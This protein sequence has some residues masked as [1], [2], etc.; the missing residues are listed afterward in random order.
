[1]KR[2]NISDN[3]LTEAGARS[4][5]RTILRGLRCF[6]MMQSCTFNSATGLF[7]HSNPSLD[8]PYTLNLAEPYEVSIL[9][10]LINMV[11]DSTSQCTFRNLRYRQNERDKGVEIVPEYSDGET[12]LRCGSNPWGIPST[13]LLTV[14]FLHQLSIPKEDMAIDEL[15]FNTILAIVV[16]ARS[17]KDRKNWLFLM[18]MDAYFTTSQAQDLIDILDDRRLLGPGGVSV[19]EFFRCIW[20]NIID[21]ENIYDFMYHNLDDAERVSLMHLLSFEKFKFNWLNATG[22]WR[23]DLN[24]RL[25]R[26]VMM[27]IIA[28]NIVESK[29]SKKAKRGDTSQKGNWCNFRNEKFNGSPCAIDMDFSKSLPWNGVL[30]FDYVATTRPPPDAEEISDE[31][32]SN[33]IL[34][35]D[36][37]TRRRCDLSR[38][39]LKLLE[40]QLAVTNFYFKASRV[41]NIMDCFSEDDMTQVRVVIVLF[42]RIV[43]L[44]NLELVFRHL[45]AG[46]TQDLFER[47]GVLN[48]INPLKPTHN[49]KLNMRFIDCRILAHTFLSMSSFESGDQLKQHPRSDV[50]IIVMYSQLG[51]VIADEHSTDTYLM[52]TYCEVGERQSE[53][54][55]NYRIDMCQKFLVGSKPWD[56]KMFR[57]IKMYKE[58]VAEKALM[59]GPI[60]LQY[61]SFIR[62]K[63]VKRGRNVLRSAGAMGVVGRLKNMTAASRT[64]PEQEGTEESS[65]SP[66]NNNGNSRLLDSISGGTELFPVEE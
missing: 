39:A 38:S 45:P 16:N 60:D 63:N 48:C 14:H 65:G 53:I 5:F 56:T 31:D 23:L 24:N 43:D 54:A 40:L 58:I 41:I 22:H 10:E 49:L 20:S 15:A 64:V 44:H 30:E 66:D 35:L 52:F 6:V 42:C 27:Q 34:K 50:D 8:S 12:F 11:N 28:L 7:K 57:I 62:N 13:G 3:P 33:F 46:P 2:L 36:L 25:Q 32:F 51:R 17:E 4:I 1:M 9:S 55:W 59:M 37:T 21:T 19:V 18:C 26:S 29:A 61:K 47:L